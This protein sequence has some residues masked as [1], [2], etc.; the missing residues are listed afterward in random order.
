MFERNYVHFFVDFKCH[1]NVTERIQYYF[2][3]LRN[4]LEPKPPNVDVVCVV[5]APND[6]VLNENDGAADAA[7]NPPNDDPNPPNAVGADVVGAVVPNPPKLVPPNPVGAD[8][9]AVLK[10]PKA[11]GADVVGAPKPSIENGS[12]WFIEIF[13]NK[14][15]F[16]KLTCRSKWG[17]LTKRLAKC[18]LSTETSGL[19][20]GRW[21]SECGRCRCGRCIK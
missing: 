14:K 13:H 12:Y 8:V 3:R 2:N 16:S 4:L 6:G 10:P 20:C 17:R 18:R 9:V 5:G 1:L 15:Q 11:G 19:R 21:C 7:P